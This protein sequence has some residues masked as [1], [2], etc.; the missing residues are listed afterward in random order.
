MSRRSRRKNLPKILGLSAAL[1]VCVGGAGVAAWQTMGVRTPDRFGCF[2]GVP[3]KHTVVMVDASTPRW[4]DE[5]G[6][7]LRQYL[8]QLF[9]NLDFNERLSVYTTEADAL[10]SVAAPRFHV[11]GQA[12]SPDELEAAGAQSGSEGY[13]QKQRERLYQKVL[14]PQLDA[15]LAQNP[16][17]ERRQSSQS[18]V[19]EMIA[20]L[21]RTAIPAGGRLVVISD[22]IQNSDSLQ[23][24]TTKNDMPR[25]AALKKRSI[26]QRIKPNSLDGVQVDVLMLQRV[27]YG[28]Y[29]ASEEEIKNFYRDYFVDAGVANPNF[30]RIRHGIVGLAK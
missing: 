10:A 26:Y 20:D 3:Q 4:N 16:S 9:V 8:D 29:C 25:Y 7:S 11:C 27:G 2:N 6:R 1:A 18:P 24:C 12:T 17:A 15:L 5:Q 13:L 28:T 23:F 19:L 14:A 22:M 30:I 21:S